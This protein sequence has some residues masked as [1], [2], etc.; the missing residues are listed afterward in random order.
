M[1]VVAP[2]FGA[3][4]CK[5]GVIGVF[6]AAYGI[7]ATFHDVATVTASNSIS[8]T[9]SATPGGVGV[10]Q[11]LNSVALAGST[12][13]ATATAYSISQQ[14]VTSAWNVVFAVLMVSWVFGWRGGKDLVESSYVDAK[15]KSREMRD[16]RKRKKATADQA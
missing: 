5:L 16:R 11:A 6:L 9:V 10:T 2:E 15:V 13:A 4:I 1:K 14:L 12:D 8:N 3:W 7:P